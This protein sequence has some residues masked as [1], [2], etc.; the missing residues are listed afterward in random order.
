M[1]LNPVNLK[2]ELHD[3]KGRKHLA[4]LVTVFQLGS[5]NKTVEVPMN[6]TMYVPLKQNGNYT[7]VASSKEHETAMKTFEVNCSPEDCGSCNPEVTVEL[8]PSDPDHTIPPTIEQCLLT[9]QAY[10]AQTN[11]WHK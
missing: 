8:E 4:G 10:D 3:S 11:K 6:G 5:M 2:I 7:I 9:V 1:E